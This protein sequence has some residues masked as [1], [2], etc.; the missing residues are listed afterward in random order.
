MSCQTS[1]E[2]RPHSSSLFSAGT[3]PS[4]VPPKS[5]CPT[6]GILLC[7][8]NCFNASSN[9]SNDCVSLDASE[10]ITVHS[11]QH[12]QC[13]VVERL[14]CHTHHCEP[15]LHHDLY[16][17]LLDQQRGLPS[18][19]QCFLQL[20]HDSILIFQVYPRVIIQQCMVERFR[21][22]VRTSQSPSPTSAQRV[23]AKLN[24]SL[25]H[26]MQESHPRCNPLV[27]PMLSACLQV[28]ISQRPI[29]PS[30]AWSRPTTGL[31]TLFPNAWC[32][33]TRSYTPKFRTFFLT[34]FVYEQC[35]QQFATE[36][37]ED[38]STG[39]RRIHQNGHHCCLHQHIDPFASDGSDAFLL[40]FGT[41]T[42]RFLPQHPCQKLPCPQALLIRSIAWKH[43]MPVDH[44]PR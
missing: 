5:G 13:G 29:R 3:C 12:H 8:K 36:M 6:L 30:F 37:S 28:W 17:I 20:P 19:V 44:C 26:T 32:L 41:L 1:S 35:I 16:H 23:A 38:S 25:T 9:M 40:F 22:V 11:C 15:D 24:T 14:C 39:K 43:S 7:T 27:L 31:D 21:P 18:F 42:S 33:G 34:T 4:L 10:V 2:I